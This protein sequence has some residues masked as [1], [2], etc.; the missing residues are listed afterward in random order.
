M[1]SFSTSLD[2]LQTKRLEEQPD[3]AVHINHGTQVPEV[4]RRVKRAW[5]LK[6]T[7][8]KPPDSILCAELERL[9]INFD[10]LTIK[11][12]PLRSTCLEAGPGPDIMLLDVPPNMHGGIYFQELNSTADRL[13]EHKNSAETCFNIGE[14]VESGEMPRCNNKADLPLLAKDEDNGQVCGLRSKKTKFSREIVDTLVAWLESH[15]NNTRPTEAGKLDLMRQTGLQR[16][17]FQLQLLCELK[18]S[19]NP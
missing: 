14:C 9:Q 3:I 5:E 18:L 16:G 19:L 10:F 12:K 17:K 11:A 7:D 4:E 8:I 6:N 1:L 15:A 13:Q 2:V